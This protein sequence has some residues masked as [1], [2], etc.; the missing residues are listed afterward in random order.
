MQQA[1]TEPPLRAPKRKL[2]WWHVVLMVIAGLFVVGVIT[3]AMVSRPKYGGTASSS[4]SNNFTVSV[5]STTRDS[6]D[7]DVNHNGRWSEANNQS[8]PWSENLGLGIVSVA[9]EN[10]ESHGGSI[11]CTITNSDGSVRDTQTSTGPYAEVACNTN[12]GNSGT[13]G[14]SGNSANSSNS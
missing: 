3:E 1:T 4:S 14:N 11:T 2:K 7:I 5:T 6:A 9:A 13:S 10:G 12:S 8:L